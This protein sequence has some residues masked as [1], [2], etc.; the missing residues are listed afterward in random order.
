MPFYTFKC[1]KCNYELTELRDMGDFKEPL[2]KDCNGEKMKK[3]MSVASFQLK[4]GG[5]YKD[6]YS[7][8]PRIVGPGVHQTPEAAMEAAKKAEKGKK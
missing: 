7:N 1:D 5:W 3:Q 2:C 4:G 6:G 8:K